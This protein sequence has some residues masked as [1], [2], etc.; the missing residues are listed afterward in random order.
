M[1]VENCFKKY[2]LFAVSSLGSTPERSGFVP[3]TLYPHRV[4]D[5]I[6]WLLNDK[7][8]INSGK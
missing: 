1:T 2:K 8:I 3:E 5:P 7:G 6:L 4:L